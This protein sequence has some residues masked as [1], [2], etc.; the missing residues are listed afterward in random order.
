MK[1]LTSDDPITQKT[2]F[3][4][5][6]DK[7]MYTMDAGTWTKD[8]WQAMWFKTVNEADKWIERH[9]L[10]SVDKSVAHVFYVP[11]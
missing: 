5:K 2:F 4:V 11:Q 3:L 1:F 6:N 9:G 7:A 10:P 8:P